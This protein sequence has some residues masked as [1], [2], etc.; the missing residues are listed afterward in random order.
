MRQLNSILGQFTE[1]ARY[2]SADDPRRWALRSIRTHRRGDVAP[3][4]TRLSPW[5]RIVKWWGRYHHRHHHERHRLVLLVSYIDTHGDF[6]LRVHCLNP[7]GESPMN[8]VELQVGQTVDF[9]IVFL[10]QNGNT[11][12]PPPTP[13]SPPSW[14]D[15]TPPTGTLTEAVG[16]LTASEVA[17]APGTDTVSVS[18]TVGGVSFSASLPITVT[19]PAPVLTSIAIVPTIVGTT[20]ATGSTGATGGATGPTGATGATGGATGPTGPTG[21]TVAAAVS[22]AAVSGIA[23]R[24]N[25]TPS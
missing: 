23:P 9:A 15:T 10:D 22:T 19:A 24:A 11:I 2:E 7:E 25:P 18:L 1:S 16:D 13:D 12:S 14:S 5:S 8:P 6:T 21:A 17:V 20:G 4:D 3:L